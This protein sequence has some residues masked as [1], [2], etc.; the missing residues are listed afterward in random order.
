MLVKSTKVF[1]KMIV[2]IVRTITWFIPALSNFVSWRLVFVQ[3]VLDFFWCTSALASNGYVYILHVVNTWIDQDA[4]LH[5]LIYAALPNTFFLTPKSPTRLIHN[6]YIMFQK[7]TTYACFLLHRLKSLRIKTAWL[8]SD[9]C[10][11]WLLVTL[12]T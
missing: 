6:K 11:L 10:L 7:S 12:S 2:V 4:P 8:S 9:K 5:Q 1:K 3:R